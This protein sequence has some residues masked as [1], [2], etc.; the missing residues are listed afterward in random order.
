MIRTENLTK[1]FR[2]QNIEKS[3]LIDVNL[4][5]EK[6]EFVSILGPSG[7]GKTSLLNILGL[8]D[9]PT[10]GQYWFDG[11][12]VEGMSDFQRT[13]FRKGRIGF[14]FQ[15]FNLIQELSVYE[16]IE[17][18]LIYLRTKASERRK[19][20]NDVLT[21]LNIAHRK[22]SLPSE[23]SGEQL[24]KVSIAR[25]IITKP[26]LI[27]A[28]EPTGNLNSVDGNNILELFT[29]INNKGTTI[30]MV[31]HSVNDANKSHRVIQLFD[32][33]VLSKNLLKAI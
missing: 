25:A 27:L 12:A 28:D 13:N 20:I 30:V 5:V 22:H 26:V 3:I 23:L 16:N 10:S 4:A 2:N 9:S 6:G 14:V 18:P 1:I 33:H 32:G 15:N 19:S 31:T 11:H 21:R 8:L 7:A 24:Q 17:L 29:D